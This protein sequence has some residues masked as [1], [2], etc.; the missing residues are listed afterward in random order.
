MRTSWCNYGG[1]EKCEATDVIE[2]LTCKIFFLVA[3]WRFAYYPHP[4]QAL[5]CKF[6]E[7]R[8]FFDWFIELT[9]D[10]VLEVSM[11]FTMVFGTLFFWLKHIGFVTCKV[12]RYRI[13]WLAL[14]LFFHSAYDEPNNVFYLVNK[15]ICNFHY[16]IQTFKVCIF[17]HCTGI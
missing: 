4:K 1:R 8:L 5:T 10:G 13:L 16:F 14:Y 12:A 17:K 6:F 7:W 15:V 9:V 11:R 3:I 2:V